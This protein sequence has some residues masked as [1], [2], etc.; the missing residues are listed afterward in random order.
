MIAGRSRVSAI[1]CRT[2][3]S[4][5]GFMSLRIE[6]C[7]WGVPMAWMTVKLVRVVEDRL[8]VRDAELVDAVDLLADEREDVRAARRR[9]R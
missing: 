7:R 9:R 5:N 4:S 2:R 8:A 1:A 3:L 6:S